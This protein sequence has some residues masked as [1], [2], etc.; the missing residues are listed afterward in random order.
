MYLNSRLHSGETNLFNLPQSKK[1]IVDY[2]SPN[3]AKE[4]HVGHLR[5][6]IIGDVIGNFYDLLE[7]DV[8][9]E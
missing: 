6:T 9:S 8:I 2:S 3:V 4:M 1:I 7:N 5:S